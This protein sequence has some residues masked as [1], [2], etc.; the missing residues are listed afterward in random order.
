MFV[1]RRYYSHFR[2]SFERPLNDEV[3]RNPSVAEVNAVPVRVQMAERCMVVVKVDEDAI[4][5][6]TYGV[7]QRPMCGDLHFSADSGNDFRLRLYARTR[8]AGYARRVRHEI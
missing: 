7:L 2:E 1:G 5:G 3:E 8:F 4:R 6:A